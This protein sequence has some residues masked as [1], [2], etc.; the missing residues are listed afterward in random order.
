MA[1]IIT[2]TI[3]TW[4]HY[5]QG[6]QRQIHLRALLAEATDRE[7]RKWLSSEIEDHQALIT[8]VN[9]GQVVIV[10]RPS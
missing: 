2:I 7:S 9:N 1:A 8:Q 5:L 4:E 3:I 6:V 10:D